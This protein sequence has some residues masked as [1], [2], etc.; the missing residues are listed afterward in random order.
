MTNQSGYS[1]GCASTVGSVLVTNL[2]TGIKK[3][4]CDT[5]EVFYISQLLSF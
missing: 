2:K 4:A 1:N 3:G 5:A